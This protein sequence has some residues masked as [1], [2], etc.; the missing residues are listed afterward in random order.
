MAEEANRAKSEFLSNMSHDIRTPMNAIVGLS[1]LLARDA[2]NPERV[3]EYTRKIIAASQ[4]LMGLIN[5]VLDMSKIESGKMTLNVMEFGLADTIE[6]LDSIMRPQAGGKKQNF[7]IMVSGVRDEFVIGDKLRLNQVLINL[8]SNAV[9]YTQVNGNI[10]LR[11]TQLPQ[12]RKRYAHYRFVVEDDGCGMSEEFQ[13]VLF[14]P[15]TREKS[16]TTNKV[17]GTGLGMAITK[18]LVELMG[19][20]IKVESKKGE[21]SRLLWNWSCGCRKR[22]SIRTSGKIMELPICWWWM[23]I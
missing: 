19:G 7:E 4:H 13:K 22:R 15:F 14:Q 5:D 11:V 9:K 3:R 23:M 10:Y 8:L 1:A 6:E 20:T 16:S 2:A 12:E 21:G 18:N 17:Q